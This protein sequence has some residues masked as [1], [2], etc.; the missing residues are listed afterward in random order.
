MNRLDVVRAWKDE[1]YRMGLSEVE[2]SLLPDNPA[3]S[4]EILL[5]VP[6][7]GQARPVADES[8]GGVCTCIGVCP[9][10]E[11]MICGVTVGACSW[12]DACSPQNLR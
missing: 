1:E 6:R 7:G 11:D 4:I 5:D 8:F 12:L 9:P 10:T 3:G 2:R